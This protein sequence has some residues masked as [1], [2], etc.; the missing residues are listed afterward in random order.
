MHSKNGCLLQP[1]SHK[2]TLTDRNGFGDYDNVFFFFSSCY[3]VKYNYNIGKCIA[4]YVCYSIPILSDRDTFIFWI[5]FSIPLSI[6]IA[7]F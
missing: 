2:D 5:F 3:K 6:S 4:D 7:S 1:I